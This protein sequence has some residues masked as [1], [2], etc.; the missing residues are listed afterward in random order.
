LSFNDYSILQPPEWAGVANYQKLL[1]D[2]VFWRSVVNTTY[3][4]F[5]TIPMGMA[6]ALALALMLNEK[7]RG[8]AV[9]RTIF[10]MPQV[11]SAVA[12]SMVWLWLYETDIGLFNYLLERI[13]L[14]PVRWLADPQTAM[15]SIILMSIWH[16]LGY[17]MIIFLAGLQ[18]I[19]EHLYEA[20]KL[21]GAGRWARFRYVTWPMLMPTTFFVF[22]TSTIGAFQVFGQVYVMTS[23]GPMDSTTV[24]VHQIYQNAFV[25][26]KMGYGAA[27]AF[28]LFLIVLILTVLNFRY[29]RSD[30]VVY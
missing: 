5:V 10:Y 30:E 9:L 4:A 7:I 28:V 19:P 23:G 15:P 26:L 14:S 25:F 1:G 17:R 8:V 29:A 12:I 6:L 13:G 27:M 21:D 16:G 20:A 3:Y 24:I 11:T 2:T 22:V 18:G